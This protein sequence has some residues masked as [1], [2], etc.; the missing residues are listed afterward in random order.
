M[1]DAF[2]IA[3]TELS[4]TADTFLSQM[5]I[6]EVAYDLHPDPYSLP[7]EIDYDSCNM[8]FVID[9]VQYIEN[10]C[11]FDQ[12]IELGVIANMYDFLGHYNVLDV[13]VLKQALQSYVTLFIEHLQV[14]PLDFYTLPG[15]AERIMWEKFD[16]SVGSPFSLNDQAYNELVHEQNKGGSTLVVHRHVEVNVPPEERVFHNSV[17]L[18]Y[19]SDAADE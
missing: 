14:N 18:L 15:M 12:L 3:K 19:T 16:D 8:S 13:V 6:P 7:D 10:M 4:M 11:S 9:P 1:R 2:E 17:C 5:S